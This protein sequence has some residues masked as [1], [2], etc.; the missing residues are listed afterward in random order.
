MPACILDRT[1]C[2]ESKQNSSSL[3]T[4]MRN[5]CI[6]IGCSLGDRCLPDV[7]KIH[8]PPHIYSISHPFFSRVSLLLTD[9]L[10][11]RESSVPSKTPRVLRPA[12]QP[13]YRTLPRV[14]GRAKEALLVAR[15][16]PLWATAPGLRPAA[17]AASAG[18]RGGQGSERGGGGA[19]GGQ[20]GRGGEGREWAKRQETLDEML[21]F[22]M[23][24]FGA[25]LVNFTLDL[26]LRWGVMS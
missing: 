23:K 25:A 3:P 21:E 5:R 9:P 2:L 18:R 13:R 19:A 12:R 15:A 16:A 7:S 24:C 22:Y 10:L 1:S 11:H 6:K 26:T 8:S 14:H 17:G 4:N 20:A